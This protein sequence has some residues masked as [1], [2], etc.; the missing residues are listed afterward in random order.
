MGSGERRRP[1]IGHIW[2]RKREGVR[3]G[4]ILATLLKPDAGTARVAGFDVL[5]E[6]WSSATL[7]NG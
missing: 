3:K 2:V 5:E 1:R 4:H 6:R 7:R